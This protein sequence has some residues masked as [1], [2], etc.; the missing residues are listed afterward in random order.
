MENTPARILE[1]H[2]HGSGMW[3]RNCF[4]QTEVQFDLY[5]KR[6]PWANED[7]KQEVI[8]EL[9]FGRLLYPIGLHKEAEQKYKEF[10]TEYFEEACLWVFSRESLQETKYLAR[11]IAKEKAMMQQ[12]IHIAGKQ[13]KEEIFSYLMNE[14]HERYPS[15]KKEDKFLL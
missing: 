13:R 8:L 15:G 6:F 9:P 12:M 11:E 1:T 3:Y 2:I 7:E 14:E 5:D 4:I 10:L